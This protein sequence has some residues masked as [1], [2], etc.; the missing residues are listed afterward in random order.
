MAS[1]DISINLESGENRKS[2]NETEDSEYTQN[3]YDN[4][5]IGIS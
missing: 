5:S 4:P 2:V 1:N 3:G